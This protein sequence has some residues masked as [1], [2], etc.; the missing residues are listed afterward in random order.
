M[1]V[2]AGTDL[3]SAPAAKEGD[4]GCCAL[5]PEKVCADNRCYALGACIAVSVCCDA[6]FIALLTN[7]YYVSFGVVF[8]LSFLASLALMLIFFGPRKYLRGLLTRKRIVS[9]SFFF[10]LT[11]LTVML[12]FVDGIEYYVLILA[13]LGQQLAWAFNFAAGFGITPCAL[14][15]AK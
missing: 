4:D 7:H 5:E 11:A 13:F 12:A 8:L 3:R 6:V 15:E 14:P 2:E 9:T 10:G 1:L